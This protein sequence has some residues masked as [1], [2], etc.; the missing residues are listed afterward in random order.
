[1]NNKIKWLQEK[2]K[3]IEKKKII[4]AQNEGEIKSE[5][6][7]IKEKYGVDILEDIQKL[8]EKKEKGLEKLEKQIEKSYTK[9]VENYGE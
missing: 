2:Q 6:K 9:L 7:S 8:K 3:E 5:L 4:K 1:M